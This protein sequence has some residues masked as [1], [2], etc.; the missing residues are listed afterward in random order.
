MTECTNGILQEN[1]V[2]KDENRHTCTVETSLIE[3]DKADSHV[4]N[5]YRLIAKSLLHILTIEAT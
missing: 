3:N 5:S 4:R 1:G 2:A